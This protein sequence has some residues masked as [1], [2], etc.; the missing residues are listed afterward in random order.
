M[1]KPSSLSELSIHVKSILDVESEVAFN[2]DGAAGSVGG[3]GGVV[4]RD[5]GGL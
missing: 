4:Q 2:E 3:G 1:V 5:D